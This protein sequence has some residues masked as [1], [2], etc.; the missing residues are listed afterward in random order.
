MLALE[1]DQSTLL[2]KF[3]P[4]SERSEIGFSGDM[5]TSQTKRRIL[6]ME[7]NPA[8]AKLLATGIGAERF[9]VETAL[10]VESALLRLTNQ[11]YD[12]VVLGLDESN[13]DH[14]SRFQDIRAMASTALVLV[15]GTSGVAGLARA[16]DNGADDYLVK[17]LS[18]IELIARVRALLRRPATG[19]PEH[20]GQ[21]KLILHRDQYRVERAG[22]SI[23]LTPREFALLEVLTRNAGKTLSRAMLTQEVWNTSGESNTNVVDVYIKYLRDKIDGEHEEKLIRTVRGMGY[24]LQA[25]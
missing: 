23:D 21:D 19:K 14:M 18:L 4:S 7:E 17:P 1:A 10:C 5:E 24:V 22:R 3:L 20:K 6:I 13:P 9:L 16:L 25:A 15:L 2:S 11:T 12:M 8:L